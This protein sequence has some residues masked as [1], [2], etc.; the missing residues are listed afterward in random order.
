MDSDNSPPSGAIGLLEALEKF[1]YRLHPT[2]ARL[3]HKDGSTE[4]ASLTEEFCRERP[5][6]VG[7]LTGVDFNNFYV[8]LRLQYLCISRELNPTE[9][10]SNVYRPGG[11]HEPPPP[12]TD[13]ELWDDAVF[14]LIG[15]LQSGLLRAWGREGTPWGSRFAIP[16]DSWTAIRQ[17]DIDWSRGSIPDKGLYCI[18]VAPN[19][20]SETPSKPQASTVGSICYPQE[21]VDRWY[22][23]RVADLES[24]GSSSSRDDDVKAAAEVFPN[25]KRD[26]VR[27]TRARIAPAQWKKTGPRRKAR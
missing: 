12:I 2:K 23:Q 17:E 7:D 24:K 18:V 15:E 20:E 27:T 11:D 14:D 6:G 21:K 1:A 25:I 4:D 19:I 8:R 26:Q 10:F 5:Y 16:S 13:Q 22:R 3:I 9:P